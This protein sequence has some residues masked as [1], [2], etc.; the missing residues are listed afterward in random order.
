MLLLWRFRRQEIRRRAEEEEGSLEQNHVDG[1][2]ASEQRIFV[3]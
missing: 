1:R 3:P 2:T